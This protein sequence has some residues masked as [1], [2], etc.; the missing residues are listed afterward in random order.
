MFSFKDM[1]QFPGAEK[2]EGES[3]GVSD[4]YSR[5]D[6]ANTDSTRSVIVLE[7]QALGP[8]SSVRLHPH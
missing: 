1:I 2:E 7:V 3:Y 8:V 6:R 5:A 4:L